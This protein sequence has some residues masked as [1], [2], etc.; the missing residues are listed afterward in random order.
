MAKD[1][2][3]SLFS[4]V[5]NL[6]TEDKNRSKLN[7]N[8]RRAGKVMNA[9][10]TG[11][12]YGGKGVK[13][14][15]K[16]ISKAGQSMTQA[17]KSL[18][19]S[20]YGALLGVP[21]A[22]IGTAANIAGKAAEAAGTATEKA[23]EASQKAG[24]KLS[25]NNKKK[26]L[27]NNLKKKNKKNN[28]ISVDGVPDETK[29]MLR[30][31]YIILAIIGIVAL[32][33]LYMVIAIAFKH[34]LS[35]DKDKEKDGDLNPANNNY[36]SNVYYEC[37]SISVDGKVYDLESYVAGVVTNEAYSSMGM[38]ALK[39][40]AVAAR[41][42]AIVT[43]DYCK[44]DI[45]NSTNA[46][47]FN[48]NF[49]DR[50]VEAANSTAGIV[51]TYDGK[52]FSSQYDSYCYDDRECPDSKCEGDTCSVTYTRVPSNE[53]HKIEIPI[54]WKSK[55]THHSGHARGMSQLLSYEMAD[56]G[57][58]YIKILKYFYAEGTEVSKLTDKNSGINSSTTA[59]TFKVRNT[60][61][62]KSDW[63]WSGDYYSSNVGQNTWYAKG[64]AIEILNE[65][66]TDKTKKKNSINVINS[67]SSN[68]CAWYNES[69]LNTFGGNKD[70][71]SPKAGSLIVWKNAGSECNDS[72]TKNY[73]HIAVIEKIDSSGKVIVTYTNSS[74]SKSCPDTWDCINF[75][76][77]E[78]NSKDEFI[79]WVKSYTITKDKKS[80][81]IGYI[82][83]IG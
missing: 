63:A 14:A 60:K 33:S 72:S 41:T 40:Q 71:N 11:A 77:K 27:L 52:L 47:T 35:G 80:E 82:N 36:L 45:E 53:K 75:N 62:T 81:F 42:F 57:Y 29:K 30:K 26:N 79:S 34:L 37:E 51:L 69:L 31:L 19:S 7:D 68:A 44:I 58:D 17:G 64:R 24:K 12:K 20:G 23:G 74:T 38:E 48:K 28:S 49:T 1:K 13:Y 15:G 55:F 59:N 50:A 18:S 32:I 76:K 56:R 54:K 67:M 66:I 22:A 4:Q 78:F 3:N 10:G 9:A 8:A 46:Q 2:D 25:E 61:P 83:I 39:A 5:S 70:I 21:M 73:G 16:G 43:T 65:A 6:N